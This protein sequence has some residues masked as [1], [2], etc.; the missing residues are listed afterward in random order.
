MRVYTMAS[1]TPDAS[2]FQTVTSSNGVTP[3][4][5][6]TR[7]LVPGT[8]VATRTGAASVHFIE[9]TTD[10]L[11]WIRAPIHT[12]PN[13]SASAFS[14]PCGPQTV[15]YALCLLKPA[16]D[17][18]PQVPPELWNHPILPDGE[19]GLLARAGAVAI[20]GVCSPGSTLTLTF[21][22]DTIS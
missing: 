14:S 6:L 21:N 12:S 15:G 1:S 20:R 4:I 19:I 3:A 7:G 10:N 16:K 18:Y 22:Y 2:T 9:Y 13:A 11:T 5:A 17:P 8:L